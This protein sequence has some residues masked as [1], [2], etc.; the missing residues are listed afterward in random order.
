MATK[1]A[2]ADRV[3]KPNTRRTRTPAPNAS[4]PSQESQERRLV[5]VDPWAILLE[6]L[7]VVPEEEPAE[8]KRGKGK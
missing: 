5:D 8:H 6:Q 3:E 1:R 7:M 4:Q 2:A